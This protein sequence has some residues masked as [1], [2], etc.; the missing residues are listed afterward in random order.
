MTSNKKDKDF[1]TRLVAFTSKD[2]NLNKAHVR[3]LESRLIALANAAKRAEADNGNSPPPPALSEADTADAENFL[4]EMLL[5][6][7]IVEVSAFQL[8]ASTQPAHERQT[9][10][11]AT[12]AALHLKGPSTAA[13]GADTAEGFIVN[14]GSRGRHKHVPSLQEW[15][16]NIR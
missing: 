10:V 1:W 9:E 16:L 11:A 14:A 3:Y 13:T 2:E 4:R 8:P 7:P 5:I 6:F 15:V 12:E